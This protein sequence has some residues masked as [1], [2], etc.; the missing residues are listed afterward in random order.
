M[1]V[2]KNF[3]CFLLVFFFCLSC[4]I[5]AQKRENGKTVFKREIKELKCKIDSLQ[6]ELEAYNATA[7]PD[8]SSLIDTLVLAEAGMDDF[9]YDSGTAWDSL[10]TEQKLSLFYHNRQYYNYPDNFSSFAQIDTMTFTS[11]IPDSVYI[12]RLTK[13]NSYIKLP[14]NQVVK[15]YIVLYTQ[16]MP[17]KISLILG[18]AQFYMPEFEAIFDQ[19]DI[20]LELKAMAVIESALNPR[21]VSRVGATGIWQFMYRT[22]RSYKLTINSY[23]DERLDPI[24]S[25]HAAAHYLKDTYNIFGDWTLA[26]ASYNCGTGN[27]NKAI[28]R[29]GG[30][31]AFWDIYPFLPRETRGY[32]PAFVAALYTLRYFPEHQIQPCAL[33]FPAHIDTFEVNKMLHFEQICAYTE[34]SIEELRDLNPQYKKDIVPG[35]ERSYILRIPHEYSGD[36]AEH[37]KEIYAFKDS[38]YF[39]PLILK[40]IAESKSS[41]S[42]ITHRVKSGQTLGGIALRYGV[43]VSDIKYW[44]G[45]R[46]NTIRIN[47]RLIIYTDR[48]TAPKPSGKSS[49][50]SS[51]R[52]HTVTRGQ[53]LGGI[54]LR[55]GLSVS[56]LKKWN[57]LSSNTIR[58]GQKLKLYDSR[59]AAKSSDSYYTVK[60]GDSLWRISRNYGISLDKLL[61]LNNFTRS[62]KIKPGQKIRVR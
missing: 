46:S 7:L 52:V 31:R 60:S 29:A 36:F 44:N 24:A 25:C 3:P 6:S 30:S 55:Y 13:M 27:V 12:H 37:E 10:D 62:T 49:G 14:Y 53:T 57:N 58:V 22:A 41:Q 34:V 50:G 21:A 39:N 42:Q 45:L 28:R 2:L 54:A 20:P 32:V 56:Q 38:V 4:S 35:I 43:R 47:Q 23:V 15:N 59:A 11:D 33:K 5:T 18:L 17:E 51:A 9:I 19:Y 1:K 26:I 61:D 48:T 16:K 40:S 8:T